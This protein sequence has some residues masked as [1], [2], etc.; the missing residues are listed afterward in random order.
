M[1]ELPIA[2]VLVMGAAV[3]RLSWISPDMFP[4]WLSI[5]LAVLRF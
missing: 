1:P 3:W 5:G 2:V 4:G